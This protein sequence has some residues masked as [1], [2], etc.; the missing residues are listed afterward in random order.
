[1]HGVDCCSGVTSAAWFLLWT[2]SQERRRSSFPV[3]TFSAANISCYKTAK[4]L[5][6]WG[7][8]A[9]CWVAGGGTAGSFKRC[10]A[11]E[12]LKDNSV[13]MNGILFESNNL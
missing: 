1:M 8:V 11:S 4:K 7:A 6:D 12:P 9:L 3:S 10:C 5:R 2:R 13:S